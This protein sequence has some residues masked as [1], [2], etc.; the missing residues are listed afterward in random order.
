MEVSAQLHVTAALPL[1]KSP[2]YPLDRKMGGSQS[3]SGH[4]GKEKHSQRLPGL[5]PPIIQ[6]A[7]Q[8]Y[9]TELSRLLTTGLMMS[10]SP[11]QG[12]LPNVYACLS[13]FHGLRPL[14]CSYSKLISDTLKHF[15]QFGG[16]R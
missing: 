7:A 16:I 12:V 8:S 14:A 4:C 11:I 15:R 13:A 2:W 5:E 9:T 6:P 1:G 10:R 3:N